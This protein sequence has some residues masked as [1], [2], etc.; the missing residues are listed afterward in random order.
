MVP[1]H[2][3]ILLEGNGLIQSFNQIM[4]SML[5]IIA[6]MAHCLP[7]Q[8]R[9]TVHHFDFLE[10]FLTGVCDRMLEF[11]YIGQIRIHCIWRLRLQTKRRK[12]II[13]I[14]CLSLYHLINSALGKM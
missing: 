11:L 4:K 10:Y 5:W 3:G 8:E 9:L 1:S 2:C 6:L 12:I 14:V 13:T 7:L